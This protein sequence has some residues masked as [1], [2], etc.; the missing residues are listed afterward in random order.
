MSVK[1]LV[2]YALE[3][4]KVNVPFDGQVIYLRTGAAKMKTSVAVTESVLQYRPDLVINI[5]TAGT[6]RHKIGDVLVCRRFRDRDITKL[7]IPGMLQYIDMSRDNIGS[8]Y[9]RLANQQSFE[10]SSGDTF[11]TSPDDMDSD[12]CDMEAFCIAYI[13]RKYRIPFAAVK[14]V[15][16]TVGSNSLSQWAD[17]LRYAVSKMQEWFNEG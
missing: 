10:C 15:T 5:G 6:V 13:C 1:L 4:E 16:D 17:A 14:S 8:L 9:P 7:N 12:V 2:T 11:V 3:E